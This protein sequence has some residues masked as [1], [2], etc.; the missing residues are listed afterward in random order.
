MLNIVYICL[1]DRKKFRTKEEKF[2]K[3]YINYA[4]R[5][6]PSMTIQQILELIK[7]YDQTIHFSDVT[8]Q[9]ERIFQIIGENENDVKVL[10]NGF[11]ALVDYV[12]AIKTSKRLPLTKAYG[13]YK[14]ANLVYNTLAHVN[15]AT[16]EMKT[17]QINLKPFSNV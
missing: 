17:Q 11:Q 12:L 4:H 16:Q 6:E 10:I 13:F 3:L 14:K 8:K 7:M 5:R 9:Y 15:C 1:K 2:V